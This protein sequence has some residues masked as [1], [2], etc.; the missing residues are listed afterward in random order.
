M[1][2]RTALLIVMI[3]YIAIGIGGIVYYVAT[4]RPAKDALV[5][6]KASDE[7]EMEEDLDKDDLD[8]EDLDDEDLDS[9][10]DYDEEDTDEETSIDNSSI[11]DNAVVSDNVIT[12][13]V[14]E[15]ASITTDTSVDSA[16]VS[17][18]SATNDSASSLDS[19][20]S[21]KTANSDNASGKTVTVTIGKGR[22]NVRIKPD[23]GAII[24]LSL[25]NGE[26]ATLL[27]EEGDWAK[28]S[29]N[30]KEGYVSKEFITIE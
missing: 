30:G 28:I 24:L 18:N 4:P 17:D 25:P 26:K 29:Y 12:N 9:E 2:R 6:A 13:A 7:D 20:E 23:K 15:D 5:T 22:L 10:E 14:D 1:K 16:T 11:S 27:S 19:D 8:D 3:L 21:S